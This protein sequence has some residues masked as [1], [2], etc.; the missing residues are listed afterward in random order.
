ML[1]KQQKVKSVENWSHQRHKLLKTDTPK[2]DPR[3]RRTRQV[4]QQAMNELLKEKDFTEVSV[5]D[6]TARADVNRATFYKHFLDKYDLLNTVIRDRLQTLLDER[7]SETAGLSPANLNILIQTVFDFMMGF[8]G[9]CRKGRTRNEHNLMMQQ[10]Q[11]QIYEVLLNWLHEDRLRLKLEHNSPEMI[12]LLTSWMI[13]GPFMQVVWGI[14]KLPK[15][16]LIR[17]VELSVHLTLE[18]YLRED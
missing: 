8:H 3:V 5:Q 15:Q 11:H 14:Y 16:D 7:L 9:D 10:V 2:V 6:I 13:F 18:N 12:A 17:Q 4:L 1:P